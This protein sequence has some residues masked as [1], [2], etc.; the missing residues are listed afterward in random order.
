MSKDESKGDVTDLALIFGRGQRADISPEYAANIQKIMGSLKETSASLPKEA[1]ETL[2]V[3]LGAYA[4][5]IRDQTENIGGLGPEQQKALETMAQN[6][7]GVAGGIV[8]FLNTYVKVESDS[9][10]GIAQAQ[11]LNYFTNLVSTCVRLAPGLATNEEAQLIIANGL[12]TIGN[13]ADVISTEY[14]LGERAKANANKLIEE[15]FNGVPFQP[16]V[17]DMGREIAPVQFIIQDWHAAVKYCIREGE[18]GEAFLRDGTPLFRFAPD[19]LPYVHKHLKL[20]PGLDLLKVND[21]V[22][23]EQ[24]LANTPI[25]KCPGHTTHDTWLTLLTGYTP[26]DNKAVPGL[27]QRYN[28]PL[29]STAISVG[30]QR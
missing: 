7:L 30:K 2:A 18:P 15:Y 13:L 20:F 11:A 6:A 23:V 12:S 29:I 22:H 17:T 24:W 5:H 16:S 4:D 9:K 1:Q 3:L 27:Y 10:I 14:F 21:G 19:C 26:K 8:D 28:A 25:G